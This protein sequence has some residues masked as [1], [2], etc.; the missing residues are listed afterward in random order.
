MTASGSETKREKEVSEDVAEALKPWK[1]SGPARDHSFTITS[2][3]LVRL[4]FAILELL[5]LRSS[6]SVSENPEITLK[7]R[8]REHVYV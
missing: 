4:D 6:D 7:G 2:L 3:T 5:N 1:S 8:R